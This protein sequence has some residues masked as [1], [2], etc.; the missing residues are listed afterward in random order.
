MIPTWLGC[1]Q[2]RCEETFHQHFAE[3]AEAPGIA[4]IALEQ[5]GDAMSPEAKLDCESADYHID[6]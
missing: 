6:I 2:G 4:G 1:I 3:F 5:Q